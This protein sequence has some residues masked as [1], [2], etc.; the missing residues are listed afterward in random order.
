LSVLDDLDDLVGKQGGHAGVEGVAEIREPEFVRGD[1]REKA[2][3][4]LQDRFKMLQGLNL[5]SQKAIR[6][7]EEVARVGEL[8]LGPGTFFLESPVEL[9]FRPADEF[10]RS[11]DGPCGDY[12]GHPFSLISAI[13]QTSRSLLMAISNRTLSLLRPMPNFSRFRLI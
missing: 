13:Y 12:S 2:L 10:V 8:D 1:R 11:A 5:Y 9:F 4:L 3:G 7:G 6:N